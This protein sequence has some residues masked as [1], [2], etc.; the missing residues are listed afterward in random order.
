MTDEGSS[1]IRTIVAPLLSTPQGGGGGA[2]GLVPQQTHTTR[3]LFINAGRSEMMVPPTPRGLHRPYACRR[4]PRLPARLLPACSLP[5]RLPARRLS[6]RRLSRLPIQPPPGPPSPSLPPPTP[7]DSSESQE[8]VEGA[9]APR[10]VCRLHPPQ[11]ALHRGC[12]A[13]SAGRSIANGGWVGANLKLKRLHA[14]SKPSPRLCR[15][16]PMTTK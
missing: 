3:A 9:A 6:V 16:A 1:I 7:P 14:A 11:P 15:L 10:R 5:R 8:S 12:P 13:R 2:E 4:L